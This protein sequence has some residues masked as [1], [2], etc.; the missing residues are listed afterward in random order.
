MKRILFDCNALVPSI[1]KGRQTGIGRTTLELIEAFE[2][3]E[4]FPFD[5]ILFSQNLKGIGPKEITSKFRTKHFFFPH[6]L[7]FNKFI[8]SFPIK[9]A[10]APYDLMH[11]PHNFEYVYNPKKTIITLHDAL[12]MKINEKAFNHLKM[13][14]RVPQLA[15]DCKGIITC[16][17]ASKKDIVETMQIDPQ[18]IDVVYWGIKHEVFY[19]IKNTD[20]IKDVL[21]QKFALKESY[22]LSVSCNTERK[23]THLLV[24]AYLELCKN[25]P[26]NDL[27]LVWG[28]PPEFI[29]EKVLRSGYAS[30]IHFITSITDEEL[31]FLYNGAT[32]MIFPSSYEG[33]GLP[34]LEAMACGCP[35][36]I[37]DNS[38]L[39]EVGGTAPIYLKNLTSTGILEVLE[40]IENNNYNL[41]A[42]IEEGINQ[43]SKFNWR[44]TAE[45]QI[46]IY[47]EYLEN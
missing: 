20:L 17:E 31:A 27:V 38:S 39:P 3:I 23:N 33:F 30:R 4:N 25:S 37:G 24:D 42:I 21:S 6:R 12:F 2:K 16:S 32:A 44:K 45:R 8:G 14:Q 7:N 36:V 29:V 19:P 46:S 41:T 43:A 13:R 1:I 35:V 18:K 26:L 10:L 9:E 40:N 22:F 5:L 15:R 34:V 11:I 47:R 28:N